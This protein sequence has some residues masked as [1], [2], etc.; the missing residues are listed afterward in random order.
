MH[1]IPRKTARYATAFRP[2]FRGTFAQNTQRRCDLE[3]LAGVPPQINLH[4][5]PTPQT[6]S[7]FVP[8][9]LQYP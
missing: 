9:R 1:E 5:T 6:V 2:S 8:G 7:V 3:Q 4:L